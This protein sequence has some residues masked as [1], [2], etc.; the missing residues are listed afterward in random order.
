[1]KKKEFDKLTKA[2]KSAGYEIIEVRQGRDEQGAFTRREGHMTV[3]IV[4]KTP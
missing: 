2:L 4:A 3:E 1:M